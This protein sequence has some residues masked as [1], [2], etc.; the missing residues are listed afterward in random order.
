[1]VIDLLTMCFKYGSISYNSS[2]RLVCCTWNKWWAAF[3]K[4]GLGNV[5]PQMDERSLHPFQNPRLPQEKRLGETAQT[6]LIW[7]STQAASANILLEQPSW[8]HLA[9]VWER[10]MA[11]YWAVCL[12]DMQMSS[13]HVNQLSNIRTACSHIVQICPLGSILGPFQLYKKLI[14]LPYAVFCTFWI[15][16]DLIESVLILMQYF[17]FQWKADFK[18]DAI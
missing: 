5:G 8:C 4:L 6:V 2:Y 1:M 16:S 18:A 12:I 11:I 9:W 13:Q 3:W 17:F 7:L 14:N 15:L 10:I